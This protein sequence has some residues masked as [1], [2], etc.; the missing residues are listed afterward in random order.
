MIPWTIIYSLWYSPGQN[1]GVSS[2]YFLQGIF[3]TQG[4]NPG[5]PQFRQILYQLSH[6]GS[7]RIQ[8]WVA[9]SCSSGSSRPRNL[10]GVSCIAGRFFINWAITGKAQEDMTPGNQRESSCKKSVR[11]MDS[12]GRKE[13]KGLSAVCKPYFL[14]K[15]ILTSL[16][17]PHSSLH[18]NHRFPFPYFELLSLPH[19]LEIKKWE[20]VERK[21]K[22]GK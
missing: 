12:E 9:C 6:K 3:P 20:K 8:E 18:S 16:L 4:S 13:R 7:P 1:T 14:L 19:T 17:T 22:R 11:V 2:L 21:K 10:T 5:L 15:K